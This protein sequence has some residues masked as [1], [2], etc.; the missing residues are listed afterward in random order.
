MD[1]ILLKNIGTLGDKHD[2]ITV[3][4]GYGRNYLIPKGLAVIAN[5]QNLSKLDDI[6]AKEKAEEESRK[7]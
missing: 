5:A 1:V 7:M 2:V 3:K 6:V 4:N